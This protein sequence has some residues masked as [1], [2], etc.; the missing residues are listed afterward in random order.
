MS[1]NDEIGGRF[2]RKGMTSGT[3]FKGENITLGCLVCAVGIF[4]EVS[5]SLKNLEGFKIENW[6]KN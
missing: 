1:K 2:H 4:L 3:P 5:S 6:R